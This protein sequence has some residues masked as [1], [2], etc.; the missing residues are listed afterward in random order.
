[1]EIIGRKVEIAQIE[2]CLQE[3]KSHFIAIYGRRRVGKTFLI[4]SYFKNQFSF[5]STGLANANLQT[6]L[7]SFGLQLMDAA[8]RDIDHLPQSWLEAFSMLIKKLSASKKKKKV[9]F[10]DELPWLD[11]RNS[12]FLTA[13]EHFWNSWASARKDILLIV[14]GS[15]ASWMINKLIKAKGGLHNRVTL[16]IKIQPFTLHETK[17]FLKNR[18]HKLDDYQI[19]QLYMALGGI[20]FY[21]EQLRPD[22][23]A[24][25]NIDLLCFSDQGMLKD[26]YS[27]LF[28]SLFN[29]A[30]RHISIIEA[31]AKKKRGLTR[32]ELTQASNMS[33]AG[34]FTR[35]L[36]EL[37][38]SSFIRK[39]VKYGNKSKEALYQLI[40][41]YSLFY[42]RFLIDHTGHRT[43]Y[44]ISQ[45]NTPQY[46]A[47][48][49]NAYEMVCLQHLPQIKKA[50][51]VSGTQ[52]DVSSWSNDEAQIDLIIDRKDRVI[53]IVEA[54]FSISEYEVT[55]S[56]AQNIN[57][58]IN[59]FITVTQ[60][61]KAVWFVLLTTYGLKKNIHSGNIHKTLTMNDLFSALG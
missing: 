24:S 31:L 57:N 1:M 3:D 55:K 36:N 27:I 7:T 53:N 10:L 18:K 25:Q 20:P 34:S 4:K 32:K 39:Y 40:D 15:A 51:G 48:A 30:E 23:S 56:Y 8:G 5:Y 12:G 44:W 41:N 47:W 28:Q 38:Q 54:K 14:C 13:L 59:Q 11:T 21:L 37:E 33:N 61:K 58:K 19:I 52:T 22:L 16:R 9:I 17:L 42:N 46:F 6:Q 29:S 35:I 26:E 60:T 50:L 43:N 49:G 2:R 45:S